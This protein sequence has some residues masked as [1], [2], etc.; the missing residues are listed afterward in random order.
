M[1][2]PVLW[3]VSFKKGLVCALVPAHGLVAPVYRPGVRSHRALSAAQLPGLP[4]AVDF[5]L[6]PAL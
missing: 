4:G 1:A 2:V 3:A 6:A 5:G